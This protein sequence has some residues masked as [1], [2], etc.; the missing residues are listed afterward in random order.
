[1]PSASGCS[2]RPRCPAAEVSAVGPPSAASAAAIDTRGRRRPEAP[3]TQNWPFWS[4]L[5]RRPAAYCPIHSTERRPSP[6]R[7]GQ[8]VGGR[9]LGRIQQG[10]E[11]LREA[12]RLIA[13]HEVTLA[14]I[15]TQGNRRV[16]EHPRSLRWCVPRPR[17]GWHRRWRGADSMGAVGGSGR[18]G[19]GVFGGDQSRVVRALLPAASGHVAVGGAVAAGCLGGGLGDQVVGGVVDGGGALQQPGFGDVQA[20]QDP[21]GGPRSSA[22]GGST[23]SRFQPL[24]IRADAQRTQNKNLNQRIGGIGPASRCEDVTDDVVTLQGDTRQARPPR[25]ALLRLDRR[26]GVLARAAACR[27]AAAVIAASAQRN[28]YLATGLPG[29]GRRWRRRS[30]WPCIR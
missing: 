6:N 7:C 13:W 19:G 8:L 5:G 23:A 9:V 11:S 26:R 21:A 28:A 10:Q 17:A 14:P 20:A 3:S 1:M 25:G 27:S 4:A 22:S 24:P 16:G 15:V 18:A 2:R 30:R 12:Q 29:C